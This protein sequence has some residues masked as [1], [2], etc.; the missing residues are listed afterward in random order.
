MEHE[1]KLS[2]RYKIKRF[3]LECI[4]VL[5]IMKKPTKTEFITILKASGVGLLIIGAIGFI[6]N[7]LKQMVI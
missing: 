4:R 6:I 2:T 1:Q 3:I 7:M 5:K